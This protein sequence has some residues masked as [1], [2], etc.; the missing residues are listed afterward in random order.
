M[1]KAPIDRERR[2]LSAGPVDDDDDE[3]RQDEPS[4]GDTT[5]PAAVTA[6]PP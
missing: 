5:M 1:A 6:N 3:L 2:R 4:S